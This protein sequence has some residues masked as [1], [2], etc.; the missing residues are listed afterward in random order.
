MLQ[1]AID[2]CGQDS[3]AQHLANI[4]AACDLD[5][6]RLVGGFDAAERATLGRAAGRY[7]WFK[8]VDQG[9]RLGR[10]VLAP[11]LEAATAPVPAVIATLR[12]WIAGLP[13]EEVD[14]L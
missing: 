1:I 3:V 4:D 10:E 2:H 6:L 13:P 5:I 8:T 14:E 12:S 9:E 7:K 11:H